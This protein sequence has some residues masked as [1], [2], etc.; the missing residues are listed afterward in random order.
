MI[1][2]PPFIDARTSPVRARQRAE[3]SADRV[4]DRVPT[5]LDILR[6]RVFYDCTAHRE[7]DLAHFDW[8]RCQPSS[9]CGMPARHRPPRLSVA[10]HFTETGRRRWTRSTATR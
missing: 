4:T 2:S 1:A 5:T 7:R 3:G 8:E 9:P 10:S 6:D